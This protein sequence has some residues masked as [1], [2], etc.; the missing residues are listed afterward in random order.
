[1]LLT[2]AGSTDEPEQ[3]RTEGMFQAMAAAEGPIGE[4]D[5]EEAEWVN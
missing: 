1:M 5:D 3:L 4:E 2:I